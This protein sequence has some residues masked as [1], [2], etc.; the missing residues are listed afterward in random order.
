M[1]GGWVACSFSRHVEESGIARLCFLAVP[2]IFGF[3][4]HH[5]DHI[6]KDNDLFPTSFPESQTKV[7]AKLPPAVA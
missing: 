2:E 1:D 4:T 3:L 7:G 5:Y 6:P